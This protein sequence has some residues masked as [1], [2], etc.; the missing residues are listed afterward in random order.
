VENSQIMRGIDHRGFL[1]EKFQKEEEESI[2]LPPAC[3]A[4]SK[5]HAIT[6]NLRMWQKSKEKGGLW[7]TMRSLFSFPRMYFNQ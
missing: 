5:K 7:R 1:L 6:P 2:A 3:R 4:G